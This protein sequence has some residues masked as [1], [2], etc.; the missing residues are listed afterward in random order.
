MEIN[1]GNGAAVG[2]GHLK[3]Q[4]FWVAY[5]SRGY[6]KQIPKV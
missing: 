3:F 5:R 2:L 1:L 6:L 4:D